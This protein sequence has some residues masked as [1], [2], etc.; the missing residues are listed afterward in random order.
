MSRMKRKKW[1][2][3]PENVR[4]PIY[5]HRRT[6]HLYNAACCG[7][8]GCSWQRADVTRSRRISCCR[9]SQ[10][11]C[12]LIAWL[13]VPVTVRRHPRHQRR[14]ILRVVARRFG[15]NTRLPI[16]GWC[17]YAFHFSRW[18]LLPQRLACRRRRLIVWLRTSTAMR[19][20][21]LHPY[22]RTRS[23]IRRQLKTVL[24]AHY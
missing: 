24:F 5:R 15:Q 17:W 18:P 1:E 4:R 7:R 13:L 22:R 10:L 3:K 14:R 12:R 2:E 23:V 19:L 20:T 9:A 11:S 6:W 8:E 21:R 16:P